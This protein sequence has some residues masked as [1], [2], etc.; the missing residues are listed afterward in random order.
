MLVPIAADG[1]VS[2]GAGHRRWAFRSVLRAGIA[3][4]VRGDARVGPSA[5]AE[6]NANLKTVN[7]PG[8]ASARAS[9]GPCE[10]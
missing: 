2:R 5:T 6:G 9:R 8:T 10:T 1:G 7:T 3:C 4:A